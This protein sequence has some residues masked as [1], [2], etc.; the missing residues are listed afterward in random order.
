MRTDAFD[1]SLPPEAI[2]QVPAQPRDAARLLVWP[3]LEDRVFREL[4]E[5]LRPGDLL[6]VNR[7]R[8]RRARLEARRGD[9]GGKVEVL[10]VRRLDTRRFS[11][12]LRP[13]RRIRPGQRLEAGPLRLEVVTRPREGVAEVLLEG[14]GDDPLEL[15]EQV[16]RLP[17]PP[18]FHGT[19]ADEERYQTVYAQ[20]AASSAAPTAG[21]HFTEE[22][23]D[24]VQARG[25]GIAGVDLEV[26]LDTF[27]PIAVDT[28]EDHPMHSERYEVPPETAEAVRSARD[29]GGRVVAVGTTTVRALEAAAEATGE[30]R[31]G[32]ATTD[33]FI[34][35]G[36]RF[37]AVDA[38]VTNF[39]APRTTLVVLVAALLG[40]RWRVVYATALERGYR[41]LSFGDAMLIDLTGAS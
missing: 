35:P 8:V 3:G 36:H 19:L 40:D 30:V 4:P 13:A 31:P 22:L 2:A 5:L 20:R 41:F 7:T 33:L 28:V 24:A 10:L 17:L 34:L 32:R 6:V 1:Y 26:G 27:R 29:R 12:L 18:Y 15:V 11:A 23:L 39:H 38:V 9:T 21:L 16:G 37:R 14:F 25:V